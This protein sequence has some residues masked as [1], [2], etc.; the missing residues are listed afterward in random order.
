MRKS[1]FALPFALAS[2]SAAAQ[3]DQTWAFVVAS[4]QIEH[5]PGRPDRGLGCGSTVTCV[6]DRAT[7]MPYDLA[8]LVLRIQARG[9]ELETYPNAIND[10]NV[11]SFAPNPNLANSMGTIYPPPG[12]HT[13]MP[14][15]N[16]DVLIHG[17]ELNGNIDIRTPMLGTGVISM[18]GVNNVWTGYW[19]VWDGA[20]HRFV[21]QS[22]RQ[23]SR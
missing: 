9:A 8:T 3:P 7:S 6:T 4:E 5:L 14:R 12:P 10:D 13:P 2:A 18:Q 20:I 11:V 22:V 17:N 23:V 15:V 21:A 16:I 1:L 19:S